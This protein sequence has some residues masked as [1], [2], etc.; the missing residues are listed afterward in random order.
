MYLQLAL[1]TM[2]L[3]V[4]VEQVQ[5]AVLASTEM[6]LYL[7]LLLLQVAEVVDHRDMCLSQVDRE[8]VGHLTQPLLDLETHLA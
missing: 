3:W 7:I 2:S 6:I 1:L 8:V 5:V 4:P